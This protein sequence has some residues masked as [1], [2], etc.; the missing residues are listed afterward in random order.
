MRFLY[1]S[2]TRI[3]VPQNGTAFYHPKLDIT[4]IGFPNKRTDEMEETLE[5]IEKGFPDIEIAVVTEGIRLFWKGEKDR[6]L[7]NEL[8]TKVGDNY[9]PSELLFEAVKFVAY[10]EN[11]KILAT[12][13]NLRD[14]NYPLHKIYVR[15]K[16]GHEAPLIKTQLNSHETLPS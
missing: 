13:D 6:F 9:M 15:D 4:S 7:T 5:A 14:L 8:P 11:W 12:S 16:T 1:N 3:P 10:D 2:R